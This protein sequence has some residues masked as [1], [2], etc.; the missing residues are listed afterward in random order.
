MTTPGRIQEILNEMDQDE[1][2]AKALRERLLGQEFSGLPSAVAQ[3]QGLIIRL[4][5]RQVQLSGATGTAMEAVVSGME[6]L[7]RGIADA[8]EI[9]GQRLGAMERATA[10][11]EQR[12]ERMELAL[13]GLRDEQQA[14]QSTI[15]E[16]QSQVGQ[17][18]KDVGQLRTD[19]GQLRTDVRRIDGRLDRGF[20]TNYEVKV[21][22]N[23]RSILGQHVGVRNSKVMKGPNLRTDED[24]ES[25]VE[26]AEVTGVVTEKEVDELWLLDLIVS[27]TLRTTHERVYVAVEASITPDGNDSTRAADRAEILRKITGGPARAVVIATRMDEPFREQA[28]QMGVET[29]LHPE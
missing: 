6:Q 13:T 11:Q 14:I 9:Q 7:G 10:V 19:A 17:I 3:N 4:M 20:G 15:A 28:I 2:L 21:A 23:I 8:V 25:K 27:G 5:E 1:E 29:A 22:S 26:N 16:T 12:T 24:F 18:Q